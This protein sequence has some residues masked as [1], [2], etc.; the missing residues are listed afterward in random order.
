MRISGLFPMKAL[1]TQWVMAHTSRIVELCSAG[2]S[3]AWRFGD[4][5]TTLLAGLVR[6]EGKHLC[7]EGIIVHYRSSTCASAASAWGSQ[8][9]ISMARYISI[10]V[11]SAVRACSCWPVV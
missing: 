5:P 4:A 8:N 2:G 10:A 11:N 7:Q 6:K 1:H 3:F 9:V